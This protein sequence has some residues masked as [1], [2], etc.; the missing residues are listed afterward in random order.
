MI[1]LLSNKCSRI[2]GK[3]ENTERFLRIALYQ[4]SPNASQLF[5]LKPIEGVLRFERD[6]IGGGERMVGLRGPRRGTGEG[7]TKREGGT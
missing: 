1:N 6:G 2:V 7:E 5:G 3:V 4:V